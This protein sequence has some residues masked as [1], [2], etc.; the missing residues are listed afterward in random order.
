[1]KLG[2][3]Q[4]YLFPYI[5]YY[6]LINSVDKF[7]LLDDVNYIKRGWINRNR[8]LVNCEEKLFSIPLRDASQNKKIKDIEIFDDQKW[9]NNLIKMIINSYKKSSYFNKV[10][11]IVENIVNNAEKNLAEYIY[12]SIIETTK[13][14][15]IETNIIKTSR[16]Y[17]NQELK[18]QERIIDICNKENADCYINPIGGVDLYSV[19]DFKKREIK[20][21][22]IKSR[23]IYYKQF[24]NDFIPWLSIIDVMM[25]NSVQDIKKML[26]ENEII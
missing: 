17:S 24:N 7:I 22:F 8:L 19:E 26:N 13:Y 2:I 25:F 21:N 16:I 14:L 4:P 12:F 20:L 18:G 9:R 10:F 15:N 6:Q 23:N 3:M 1:M 11:P 5:G